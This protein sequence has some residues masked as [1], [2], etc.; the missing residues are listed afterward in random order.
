LP[1]PPHRSASCRHRPLAPTEPRK[2]RGVTSRQRWN[3]NIHYHPSILDALPTDCRTALDVGC[4][5]GILA[6]ELGK[7]VDR[8]TGI[9]LDGPSI[10]VARREAESDNVEY[11]IGDFLSYDFNGATF[12]AVVSNTAL[13]HMDA[14]AALARMHELLRPGGVL[15]I[16]GWARSKYPADLPA[17]LAGTLATRVHRATKGFWKHSA[18]VVWTP[19]DTYRETRRLAEHLLPGVR[20]RRHLL[21][22]YSLIWSKRPEAP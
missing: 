9:D 17:D 6:G 8:V 14:A 15:A 18:P 5:E 12:D 10:E 22:R 13:H 7:V 21:W 19:P 1:T 2:N 3:H 11:L 4:S 20:Y 16:V